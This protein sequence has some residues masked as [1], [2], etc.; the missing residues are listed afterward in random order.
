MAV[1]VGYGGNRLA[2]LCCGYC[3]AWQRL[4]VGSDESALGKK[5]HRDGSQKNERANAQMLNTCGQMLNT[6]GNDVA[7]GVQVTRMKNT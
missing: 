3:C 2:V 1:C 4:P 6:C 7:T 5:A